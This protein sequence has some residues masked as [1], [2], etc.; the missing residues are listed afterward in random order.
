MKDLPETIEELRSMLQ[1]CS[2]EEL[3]QMIRRTT[4][5]IRSGELDSPEFDTDLAAWAAELQREVDR[6]WPAGS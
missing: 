2:H 4:A 3:T 6:R 5:T 1:Q